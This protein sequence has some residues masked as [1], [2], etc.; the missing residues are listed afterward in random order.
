MNSIIKTKITTPTK[1]KLNIVIAIC[2]CFFVK[3]SLKGNII[4][5]MYNNKH[6]INTFVVN[7]TNVHSSNCPN[8]NIVPVKKNRIDTNNLII[9]IVS[10]LFVVF[11]L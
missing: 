2:S 1:K 5:P 6:P 8:I 9:F 11:M 3:G 4:I 10:S 7:V